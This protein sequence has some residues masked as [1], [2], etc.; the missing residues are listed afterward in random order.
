LANPIQ[1]FAGMVRKKKR[2][3][4]GSIGRDDHA[5]ASDS[6]VANQ[7]DK[8]ILPGESTTFQNHAAWRKIKVDLD[9]ASKAQSRKRLLPPVSDADTDLLDNDDGDFDHQRNH[10]DD[11]KLSK[12]SQY[13]LEAAPGEQVAMMYGS[14]IEVLDGNAFIQQKQSKAATQTPIEKEDKNP[15]RKPSEPVG[16]NLKRAKKKKKKRKIEGGDVPQPQVAADTVAMLSNNEDTAQA[17]ESGENCAAD[18]SAGKQRLVEQIQYN[19][20]SAASVSLPW[21]ICQILQQKQFTMPTPIQAAVLPAAILGRRNMVSYLFRTV[22]SRPC[23]LFRLFL[24]L[25]L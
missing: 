23:S 4:H 22:R 8:V 11:V 25:I 20:M 24:V 5:D 17:T 21:P 2:P 10:Y 12:S 3:R 9:P 15:E 19:W 18:N 14:Y 7:G 13:D 1:P 6:A 16:D